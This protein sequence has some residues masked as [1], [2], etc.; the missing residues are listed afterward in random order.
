V[1]WKKPKRYAPAWNISGARG[2]ENKLSD[3]DFS[4]L[5]ACYPYLARRLLTNDNPHTQRALREMLHGSRGA[6]RI[7]LERLI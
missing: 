2:C 4:I 5:A 7:D 6:S 3:A 1:H